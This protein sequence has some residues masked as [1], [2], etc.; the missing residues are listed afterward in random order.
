MWQRVPARG[1][2]AGRQTGFAK[3]FVGER[4]QIAQGSGKGRAAGSRPQLGA[5]HAQCII[6]EIYFVYFLRVKSS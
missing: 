2:G 1:R 3:Y 6:E 5:S 4:A